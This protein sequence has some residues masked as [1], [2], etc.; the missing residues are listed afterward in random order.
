MRKCVY[1]VMVLAAVALFAV[2]VMQSSDLLTKNEASSA[3]AS[4]STVVADSTPES[5]PT[6]D[7][8]TQSTSIEDLAAA[9]AINSDAMGWLIVPGTDI[10]NAVM[11]SVNN[12]DY[13]ALNEAGQYD[14]WG[15]YFADYYANIASPELLLQN[16][17]IYGHAENPENPDGV[18]FSQLFRYVDVEGFL[19]ENPYIYLTVGTGDASEELVFEVF[20]VFFTDIDF[21]YINPSPSSDDFD[22]FIDTVQAKNEFVLED[23]TV[24]EDDKLL[25]LSTCSHRYDTGNT[26]D[27]RLVVMAKLVESD[28]GTA[29][30]VTAN[31]NA[32]HP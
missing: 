1:G 18:R 2:L 5:E 19:T 11:Q 28:D 24:T 12:T 22:A 25:T 27:Q 31:P 7:A 21:Y 23:Y 15:S 30:I 3:E 13:L 16:T 10:D 26:R 14:S 8:E 32:E 9:K 6:V 29:P 4:E 17:V 20:A